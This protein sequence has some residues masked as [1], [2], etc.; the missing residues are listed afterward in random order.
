MPVP[1]TCPVCYQALE[2]VLPTAL[3]PQENRLRDEFVNGRL[4]RRP[5]AAESM[6]LTTFMHG[7]PARL[8]SCRACGMLLREEETRAHYHNEVYDSDLMR[9]LYPRYLAAFRENEAQVRP[10]LRD[11]AEVLEVGSHLGSFLQA[12]EEWGWRAVGLDIG[13]STSAFAR[14]LGLSVMR[15]A[16]EDY[17]PQSRRPDALFIWNCFEQLEDPAA[18]LHKSHRV[19]DRWGLLTVRVPNTDFY[20]WHR[21]RLADPLALKILGYNNLLGFP[22]L[23]GYTPSALFKLL[24]G[25]GFQPIADGRDVGDPPQVMNAR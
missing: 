2:L 21:R 14:G 18:A 12:S 3:V 13:A 6:D 17:S 25:T 7:G 4:G 1:A 15:L 11:G 19:L 22:Y 23:H 20:R 16:L 10:L 24:R 8:L 9:H 5:E